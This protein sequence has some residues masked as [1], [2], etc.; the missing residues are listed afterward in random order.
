MENEVLFYYAKFALLGAVASI[1]LFFLLAGTGLIIVPI[2][3]FAGPLVLAYY[4]K[5]RAIKGMENNFRV[6][7]DDLK[8]LLQAGVNISD[9]LQ[10][11]ARNDYGPL[12]VYVKRL[13]AKVKL[14][15]PFEKAM[16]ITFADVRSQLI[17]K[18]ITVINQTLRTGGNFMKV[19]TTSA[20]YVEKIERLKSQRKSRTMSTLFNAYMMFYVFVMIIIAIQVYFVPLIASQPSINAAS[21]LSGDISSMQ[22]GSGEKPKLDFS[23][24]FLNL[25]IVQSIFAGPMIGKIS[26]NSL[27]AGLKHC[28]ILLSTSVTAYLLATS[29][30]A[31]G[32]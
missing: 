16:Q 24:H 18:I 9:A 6:L 20:K 29:L 12:S 21:L 32:V 27:V 30:L 1:V 17:R 5:N 15:I 8:D 14:G 22:V 13:A 4:L 7:L 26:E 19:F 23:A 28:L 3:A 10:I 25:L 31:P 11:T 2:I